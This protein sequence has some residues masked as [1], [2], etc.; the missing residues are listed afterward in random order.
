MLDSLSNKSLNFNFNSYPLH[1]LPL[2]DF[3]EIIKM[4]QENL[5]HF[6]SAPS[7]LQ[8]RDLCSRQK[9][10]PYWVHY[11]LLGEEDLLGRK[12][13]A[14]MLVESPLGEESD[15]IHLLKIVVDPRYRGKKLGKN[16][17][18]KAQ[19]YWRNFAGASDQP[20]N[21]FLEVESENESAIKLYE[22][23]GFKK[24]HFQRNFYSNQT[25]S[26]KMLKT[27]N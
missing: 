15:T 24:I 26:F 7:W 23:E 25:H 18:I 1:Q 11:F 3:N 16:L 19:H 17:L 2:E 20:R 27:M 8:S 12:I 21:W 13:F 4:D 5:V 14:W 9:P 22:S 6:W 10:F